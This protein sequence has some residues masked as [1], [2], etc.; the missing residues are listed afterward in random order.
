MG[1]PLRVVQWIW[2]NGKRGGIKAVSSK[3][4]KNCGRKLVFFDPEAI[5]GVLLR[6][7]TKIQDLV[8]ALDISKSTL[9]RRLREGKFRRHTNDIKFT[10]TEENKEHEFG[11]AS[12]C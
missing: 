5:K 8:S 11:F 10:L 1:V 2:L 7:R 12:Q 4:A 3:K 9:F 6:R